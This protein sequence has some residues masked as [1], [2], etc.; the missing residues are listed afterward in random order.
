M[1]LKPMQVKVLE[2]LKAAY[3]AVASASF[4]QVFPTATPTVNAASSLIAAYNGLKSNLSS[5]QQQLGPSALS[6]N[7]IGSFCQQCYS[8]Y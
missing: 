8:G 2:I 5:L 6:Q 3:Q 7:S 1:F 4:T